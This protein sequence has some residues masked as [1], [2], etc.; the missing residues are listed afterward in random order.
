MKKAGI[1][2]FLI[3]FL[4]YLACTSLNV[5]SKNSIKEEIR[6]GII[7][8]ELFIITMDNNRYHFGARGFRIEH[9]TLYGKGLKIN[10]N[11]EELFEGKIPLDD[12]SHFE[13]EEID[14]MATVGLVLG[15]AAILAVVLTLVIASALTS[16]FVSAD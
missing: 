11:N 14:A 9:D 3:A 15:T 1:S 16:E 5:V 12:I 4:N 6:D 10:L 2:F 8:N 13:V 7:H